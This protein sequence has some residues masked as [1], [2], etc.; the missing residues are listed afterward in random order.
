MSRHGVHQRAVFETEQRKRDKRAK[1]AARAAAR[2]AAKTN[3]E[4]T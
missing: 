2:R 4:K 3:E 1:K